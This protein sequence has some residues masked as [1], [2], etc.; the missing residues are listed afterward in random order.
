MAVENY[1]IEFR[2][3]SIEKKKEIFGKMIENCKFFVKAPY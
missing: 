2:Y 1:S 3:S